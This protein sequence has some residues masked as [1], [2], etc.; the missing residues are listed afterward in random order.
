M[1]RIILAMA[2]A[3][4]AMSAN[5][6]QKM[7]KTPAQRLIERLQALQKRGV[8]FGHQD[9]LFLWNNVEMGVWKK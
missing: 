9:A 1:K 7:Q 4:L 5:A 3:L 6:K 8:M 2:I